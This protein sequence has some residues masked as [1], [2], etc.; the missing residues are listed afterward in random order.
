MKKLLLLCCFC[1]LPVLSAATPPAENSWS[2]QRQKEGF[3]VLFQI[4]EDVYVYEDSVKIETE[5]VLKT[6]LKPKS[7]RI[8]DS[9]TGEM[10]SVYTGP[11][12]YIWKFSEMPLSF[13]FRIKAEWQACSMDGTC[14]LPQSAVI[15]EYNTE[16]EWIRNAPQSLRVVKNTK[17]NPDKEMDSLLI[18][19]NYRVLRSASGYMPPAKFA[20]FLNGREPD[21]IHLADKGILALLLIVLSGGILLNLT[22][23][24]LPLIPVNLAMMGLSGAERSGKEKIM[25]GFIYGLGITAA[26]GT[27]GVIAV[28]TGATFG[29]LAGNWIFNGAVSFIFLLLALAMFGVF[30]F[31]LSRYSAAIRF[32]G[33]LQIGGIFLMGAVSAVLAGA[34][35]APVLAAVLIQAGTLY[36]EGNSAGLFLPFLLGAGMALPWPFA[37]AGLSL[38]PKPGAW[39]VRIKQILGILI[40]CLSVYYGYLTFAML[41]YQ[42]ETSG[43][44]WLPISSALDEAKHSNKLVLLDFGAS[45][46]K[47]CTAMEK[48]TF[49]APQVQEALQNMI[50]VRIMAENPDEPNTAAMLKT[51]DVTGLPH[52]VL[53]DPEK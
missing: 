22:P 48:N 1:F 46:C 8:R 17:K 53:L 51:F 37:A 29:S 40:L 21:K 4:P 43:T 5:P 6:V 23:C 50:V 38:F 36:A 42:P 12:T 27:L 26:Y 18:I 20:D 25:R 14:Y 7:D 10:V 15:A 3:A 52:Y 34:C 19:P 11:D 33:T 44:G 13:P 39:M 32:P 9:I 24:V 16:K 31:D 45:W 47:N 41:R 28:L 30:Q 35:V 49:P 2:V